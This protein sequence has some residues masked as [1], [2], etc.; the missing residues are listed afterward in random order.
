MGKVVSQGER[1]RARLKP[2]SRK[3]AQQASG[4]RLVFDHM[5]VPF[6]VSSNQFV[7][8]DAAINGP[9][10]GATM[11]GRIDFGHDTVALTGTYVPLY[12]VNALFQPLPVISDILNGR[13]NEGIFGIT[14]AVQGRT[15]NPDIVVNPVSALAPGFLRQIFEF[16]NQ[17]AHTAQP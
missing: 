4:E 10:L 7:L 13:N 3:P 14:F 11:R 1:E 5:V 8:Q 2:D 6:S 17:P 15:S 9:L 16:E 12:G